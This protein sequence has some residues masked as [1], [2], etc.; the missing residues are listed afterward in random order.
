MSVWRYCGV[1]ASV[2][3][4]RALDN[5]N[6]PIF[7]PPLF[8]PEA[9]INYAENMLCG[10]ADA[11]A[12]I[13]MNENNL[14]GPKRYTWR[15]LKTLVAR[16]A[17]VLRR[18]GVESE[19]VVVLVG[20]NCARSLAILLAAASLGA[21]FASFQTDI[22]EKA[23]IDRV[24]QLQPKLM[25]AECIYRYNGKVN[26]ITQ[27]VTNAAK[28]TKCKLVISEAGDQ[29]PEGAQKLDNLIGRENDNDLRFVQVPCNHPF[30]VMFSSGTT[31]LPKGIVHSQGGLMINGMKEHLL[32]NNLGP[33][34]IAHHYSGVGWTLWNISIGAMFTGAAMV[35]YDGSPFYPNCDE[36]LQAIFASGVTAYGSS[37]RYF[38]ELQK[39]GV[40]PRKYASKMH[41][42]LS[43][44]ALL[45][46]G[47]ASWI[48]EAFGPVCQIG[49]SGGTELCGSFMTGTQ[50]LPC[51]PGEITV[52]ELGMAVDVFGPNGQSLPEG[53]A[54][55]LVC[56]KPFPNM[57]VKFWD[58]PEGK[59]YRKSYF[60]AF[61]DTKGI[62]VLG[63]SDGVLNPS[64]IRFGTAELYH[65]LT[66]SQFSSVILDGLAVGQQ[67]NTT[68]YSDPAERVILFLKV[69]PKYSTGSTHPNELLVRDLKERISQDLS[70]RHV[71]H[72]FFEA[73]EIPHNAN[74]KKMEIQVKQVCNGGRQALKKMTLTEAEREMLEKFVKFYNLEDVMKR[75]K[76]TLKL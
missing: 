67:R 35:L 23:L 36:F 51:Y 25:L 74:G 62:Y 27:K 11:V 28:V 40:R 72:F 6:P 20:G 70:K 24:G 55:E 22:G 12:V 56:K 49:F 53:D 71:P 44:G 64:G 61:P 10:T 54:G 5:D 50:S 13:E 39:R 33:Q 29:I 15:E 48:A 69:S 58:D 7:P 26:E 14:H 37:P 30:V 75:S 19:D 32:H 76:Q 8:F 3:P 1:R 43:T 42:V 63:R 46:P 60:E 73:D 45:T 31:G 68:T 34:D 65:V 59:R 2:Q 4:T 57:P 47:T 66:S 17:G 52:K 21:V 9:R 38:S 18:Q 41:T 16:Y